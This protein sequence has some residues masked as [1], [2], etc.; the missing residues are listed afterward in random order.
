MPASTAVVL[1][2]PNRKSL[3]NG[4]LPIGT[5]SRAL[6]SH[7]REPGCALPAAHDA[8]RAAV[9]RT[10]FGRVLGGA[11][12]QHRCYDGS[13]VAFRHG[14]AQ[15]TVV[16][17]ADPFRNDRLYEFNNAKLALGL[18]SGAPRLIW[19]DLHH[20]ERR[21]GYVDDPALAGQSAAP[22]SLGPQPSGA[23]DRDFPL[24]GGSEPEPGGEPQGGGPG[25]GGDGG[26]PLAEAF[27]PWTYA[28]ALLIAL[29]ALLLA[30]ARARRRNG[31]LAR[32]RCCGVLDAGRR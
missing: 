9:G 27:P 15:I 13:L 12:E 11:V 2:E 26:N 7:P 24:P 21:P 22:P 1:V 30:A 32:G 5:P 8:G 18:L 23:S 16:G 19:L 25:D 17:S 6:T 20:P 28:S 4:L 3:R 29:A 31:F 14:S 10:V